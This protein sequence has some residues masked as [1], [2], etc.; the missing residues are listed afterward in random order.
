M[1]TADVPS[2][3][4]QFSSSMPSIDELLR[5][6][7]ACSAWKLVSMPNLT[8][9]CH[10][11]KCDKCSTYLEHLLITSCAGELCIRP[12]GLE[13]QLDHAWPVTMDDIRR[14][15]GEPLAKRLDVARD[16]CDTRDD[17]VDRARQT[18]N[19]LRDQLD[20]EHRLRC[21]LEEKLAKY[22]GKHKEESVVTMDSP[23]LRKRQAVGVPPP[24][25][26]PAIYMLADIPVEVPVPPPQHSTGVHVAPLEDDST[27][28]LFNRYYTLESNPDEAPDPL[29]RRLKKK[30]LQGGPVDHLESHPVETQDIDMSPAMGQGSDPRP[31]ENQGTT[32]RPAAKQGAKQKLVASLPMSITGHVRYIIPLLYMQQWCLSF[33][34]YE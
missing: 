22:K 6:Y 1:S 5:Q 24:P 30:N 3:T 23:L 31:F 33:I 16:L 8:T 29:K 13:E 7:K 21:R 12:K 14:D 20:A 32:M 28:D 27:I 18:I 10:E 17:E 4:S 2:G 25:T 11:H 34:L 15:V 9:L 19:D 26:L